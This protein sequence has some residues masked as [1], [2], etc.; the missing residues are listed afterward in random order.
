MPKHITHVEARA[1][2]RE[3]T[4]GCWTGGKRAANFCQLRWTD[5]APVIATDGL[6]DGMAGLVVRYYRQKR[7]PCVSQRHVLKWFRVW[8]YEVPT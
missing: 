4:E 3:K 1:L 6:S 5:E 8:T 7:I 2:G